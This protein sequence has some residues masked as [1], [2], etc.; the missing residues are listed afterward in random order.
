[1]LDLNFETNLMRL[2]E[3]MI[4]SLR[5][6][7][8]AILAHD[9]AAADE[10]AGQFSVH[11]LAARTELNMEAKRYAADLKV[12]P[13]AGDNSK[14]VQLLRAFARGCRLTRLWRD[15]MGEIPAG[16]R[17]AKKI[18]RIVLPALDAIGRRRDLAKL[19]DD[20]DPSVRGRAA[21]LLKEAMPDR[22]ASILEDV[23]RKERFGDA[24][25]VVMWAL[26][27]DTRAHIHAEHA[28]GATQ[29]RQSLSADS[30]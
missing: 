7:G 18:Y 20:P 3:K 25:S 2:Q 6:R 24:G 19:L 17:H 22:C 26:S 1:M 21:F 4:E 12:D 29:R 15:V 13:A 8:K 11:L 23:Y 27:D 9:Q 14:A 28:E 10:A 16:T 30:R 5:A